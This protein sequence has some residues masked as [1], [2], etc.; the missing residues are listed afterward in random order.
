MLAL[1]EDASRGALGRSVAANFFFSSVRNA[2][3]K[4]F[5]NSGDVVARHLMAQQVLRLLHL[6]EHT[7]RHRE[8]D[9]DLLGVERVDVRA[10]PNWYL[11]IGRIRGSQWDRHTR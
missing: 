11:R 8:L 10:G 1:V 7:T 6:G 5:S 3:S 9:F 2:M 4:S